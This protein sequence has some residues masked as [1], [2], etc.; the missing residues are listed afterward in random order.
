MCS[1][2]PRLT[3]E[4]RL[5]LRPFGEAKKRM[6]ARG[7]GKVSAA[8]PANRKAL[9]RRPAGKAPREEGAARRADVMA[10]AMT[11]RA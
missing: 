10:Q 3:D 4:L 7:K 11:Y 1:V 9:G 2:R 6:G 5:V 8:F